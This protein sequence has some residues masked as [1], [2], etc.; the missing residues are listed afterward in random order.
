[1]T[2]LRF[3]HFAIA[4]VSTLAAVVLMSP[5]A[6]SE[7]DPASPEFFSYT[8]VQQY[9]HDPAAFTQGLVWDEGVVYE[10]TGLYGKSS[11]RRVD[12][13]TGRV[14]LKREYEQ[15]YFAEGITIFKGTVYQLTWKNNRL[16]QYDKHDLSLIRS[17]EFPGQG[18]GITNDQNH[19]IVS[20]GTAELYFLDPETLKEIRKITVFDEQGPVTH[21]NELEYIE[22]AIYANVW[23]TG[24]I[25][26]IKPDNGVVSGW[27]D[28]TDLSIRMQRENRADV[29]NGIM[30][31]PA[32]GRLF[33]TGKLWPFIFEIK[34][35]SI[36]NH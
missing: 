15:Q 19:L 24:R 26:I 33:V 17:W 25:A 1:M 3:S 29:L 10:G 13:E 12:L 20:N 18:W 22:G 27:L 28:L 14:A 31:D 6:G 2:L 11:L 7:E 9:P 4:L 21:L 16:F 35:V 8:I 30:F 34:M 36:P 23:P 5:V 32:D